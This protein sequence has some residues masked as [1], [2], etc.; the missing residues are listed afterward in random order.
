[1]KPFEAMASGKVLI[2]SSVQALA[3]IVDDG[4]TGFVFEKDN[5]NDLAAKLELVLT[6]TELRK[7]IGKNA[8]KWVLENNSW[9]VISKRVTDI[10]DKILEENK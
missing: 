1:M 2:T 5:A 9:D 3:E 6:D 10:Y 7:K 4:K 8:N